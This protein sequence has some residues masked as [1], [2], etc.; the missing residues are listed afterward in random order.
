MA[1]P[2]SRETT[3]ASQSQVESSDL[4]KIQDRIVGLEPIVVADI[5]VT[6]D[7]TID[8]L[9]TGSPCGLETGDGPF[10]LTTTGTIPT[11]LSTST[12]YWTNAP[13]GSSGTVLEVCTSRANALLGIQVAFS[14]NGTG[15]LK[16]VDTATTTRVFDKTV[17]RDLTVNGKFVVANGLFI[18]N[19]EGSVLIAGA[20][21]AVQIDGS[22]LAQGPVQT[23]GAASYYRGHG[24]RAAAPSSGTHI[25]GEIVFNADPIASGFIGWV[26]V[27]AGTPGTWKSWGAIS[28]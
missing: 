22:V 19:N 4:N 9:N 15:T 12:D 17:H 20:T 25:V 10:R 6:P 5:T 14:D 27:T 8:R 7:H 13:F 1:F 24:A 23:S 26:C 2:D 28:A 11:G 18:V 3:Y 21:T 16:I